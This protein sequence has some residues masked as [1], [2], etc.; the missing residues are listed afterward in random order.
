M[1]VL[2]LSRDEALALVMDDL[3]VDKMSMKEVTNDL[4]EEQKKVVKA[5]TKTGT[6]T[7]TKKPTTYKFEKKK[8]ENTTKSGVIAQIAQFLQENSEISYENVTITNAERQISFQIG[9]ETYEFTL[10]Q[11]RKPKK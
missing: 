2:G 3:E 1:K 8:K 9:D 7:T 11:K 6:K 10:V 5:N 4:T